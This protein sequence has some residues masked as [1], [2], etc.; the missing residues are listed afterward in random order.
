MTAVKCKTPDVG[1]LVKKTDYYAKILDTKS[2]YFPTIIL[3][4]QSD[5]NKFISQTLDA[6][7][8]WKELINLLLLDS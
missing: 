7:I 6:K 1:N 3:I 2:N 8:K 5:Y 4:S